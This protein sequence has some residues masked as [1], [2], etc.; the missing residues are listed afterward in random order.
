MVARVILGDEPGRQVDVGIV[1]DQRGIRRDLVAAHRH[2]AHALGSAGDDGVRR[3][4]P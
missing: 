2:E 3:S 1:V 4:A